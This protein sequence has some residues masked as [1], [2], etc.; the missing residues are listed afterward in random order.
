MDIYSFLGKNLYKLNSSPT[1]VSTIVN[2]ANIDS[3]IQTGFV[4]VQS[5]GLKQ[6]KTKFDNTETGFILGIDGSLAKFYIGNT[7]DYLNWT[8][9][10]LTIKGTFVLG[11]TLVTVDDIANLA[12]AITTVSDA[13]GGTVALVPATYTATSSFTIPSGV[14]L[15]MNGATIDFDNGAYQILIEGTNAYSTGTL[16][17]NYASGSV[18]G[19]LTVWTAS[20]VGQSILIG[21]YWYT[22]TARASDTAI[23]ISP[24]FQAP[25]VSGVTYVIA[26]TVD[27]VAV[28]NGTLQNASGTLLKYR[29]V[30]GFLMDGLLTTDATQGIDGDDSANIQWVNSNIEDCTSGM[31][32]NNVRFCTFNNWGIL[33]ITGGTGI[34]LNGVSNT[35]LGIASIQGIVGVGLKFTNCSNLGFINYSI[36]E[37]SSHGIECVSGNSA[38]DLISGYTDTVGGDGIKLT[39]TSDGIHITAQEVKNYTGYGINIAASSCDNNTIGIITYGGGG[40]GT[41]NDS[42]TGTRVSASQQGTETLTNKTLTSPTLTTPALGTPAS[43]VL[44]NCTGLPAASVLAGSLGAGAFVI[45]TSLQVATIELSHATENTLSASSG[46]LSIEGVAIPTISSTSTLTN[47]RVQPRIVSAASYTTDTG[48]SLNIDNLDIFIV[49]AQAGALLFNAPGGTLAQ[50]E[51][52]IIRIKDNGTARALTWNAVFR[53][54][55]TALPS[56]TV[57]S[58]TLYLGFFYNSTDTKWDLVASAQES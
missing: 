35:A 21:D 48:T 6:G 55:G 53:A 14:T 39:A 30:N 32:A 2:P 24:V 28:V 45:S 15:D 58:K 1:E 46:V 3:G 52:L 13:G 18:T 20:M 49:T 5:G 17:V 44:T 8:G 57:L 10:Q 23:T 36:I 43:G 54:L 25:N 9:S 33:N 34:D 7:T 47:K 16:A 4:E 19:T 41:L 40:S 50:G 27:D 12:T 11:G 22:I 26:T 31:T 29:Y 37:C 51:K 38:L 56:T 42:G